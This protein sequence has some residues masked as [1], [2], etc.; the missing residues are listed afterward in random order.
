MIIICEGLRQLGKSFDVPP[1]T[2]LSG[3]L[4]VESY[5][6][7][8]CSISVPDV[9]WIKP[10][11]LWIAICMPAS[12]GKSPFHNFLTN[13]LDRVRSHILPADRLLGLHNEFSTFLMQIKG[14]GISESHD[15]S[16]FLPLCNGKSWNRDTGI[17]ISKKLCHSSV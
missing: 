13:L 11:L 8:H 4:L 16:T 3:L 5:C 6:L 7:S 14:K 9:E 12:S 1:S 10:S 17:Y 2:V 15:L